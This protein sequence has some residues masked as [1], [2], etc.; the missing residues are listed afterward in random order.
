M[1]TFH[2][3]VSIPSLLYQF[4]F[5]NTPKKAS[6]LYTNHCL[7]LKPTTSGTLQSNRRGS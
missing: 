2:S 6:T 3:P 4:V 1:E 7:P 5:K